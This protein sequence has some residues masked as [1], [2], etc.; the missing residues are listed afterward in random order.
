[1]KTAV[2]SMLLLLRRPLLSRRPS[3]YTVALCAVLALCAVVTTPAVAQ[4]PN[5]ATLI[6]VVVDE[7]GQAMP[8][9]KVSVVNNATGATRSAVSAGDGST[10]IVALSLTGTYTVRVSKEGFGTEERGD[11]RLRSGE[12]ATLNFR[13]MVGSQTAEVTVYGTAEGAPTR[14]S[15]AVSTPRRS[16][17]PRFSAAS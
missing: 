11:I 15:A 5:T 9:A 4:S 10:T 13:L 7:T 12:T 2:S 16:T 8:D 6:V 1:M 17:R 3:P 14:R